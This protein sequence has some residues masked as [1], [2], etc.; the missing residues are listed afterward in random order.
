MASALGDLTKIISQRNIDGNKGIKIKTVSENE[1][2]LI[3]SDDLIETTTLVPSVN[4]QLGEVTLDMKMLYDIVRKLPGKDIKIEQFDAAVRFE[5]GTSKFEISNLNFDEISEPSENCE[6]WIEVASNDLKKMIDRTIFSASKD[7]NKP[8][9]MGI[10]LESAN[11]SLNIV[12]IDGF[13]L[14]KRSVKL[15]EGSLDFKV[16][17]PERVLASLSKT[18][19]DTNDPIKI[20]ID[21]S[22]VL[23]K[24][25]EYVVKSK[26]IEGEYVDYEAIVPKNA[27]NLVIVDKNLLI[28]AIDRISAIIDDT[29]RSPVTM[30]FEDDVMKLSSRTSLGLAEN[31]IDVSF[32]GEPIVFGFNHRFLKEAIKA[33]ENKEI[34]LE[35]N[36]NLEPMSIA[37][38]PNET[39]F[40]YLIL[41]VRLS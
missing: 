1:F 14:S 6:E 13:R 24:F 23:F 21:D 7:L 11:D 27:T 31:E 22:E 33:C 29:L 20:G 12:A 30:A 28:G 25:K 32:K 8:I 17:L 26:T 35:F 10:L 9:L 18:L 16:I 3:A 40:L 39:E 37:N 34:T 19:K 36:T 41:P 38:S 4:T 5:S 15:P 2:L